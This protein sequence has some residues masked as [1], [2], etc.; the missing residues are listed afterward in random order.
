MSDLEK[1]LN[2]QEFA[3]L[4][5]VTTKILDYIEQD[6]FNFSGLAK[7]IETDATL[8]MKLIKVANS[9]MFAMKVNINSINQVVQVLGVNRVANLVLAVSIFSKFVISENKKIVEFINKVLWHSSCVAIVA[10]SISKK[11]NLS[12]NEKEFTF[13][14]LHDMGKLAML[15]YDPRR[16]LKVLEMVQNEDISPIVAD[17]KLFDCTHVEVT[18]AILNKWKMPP[19]FVGISTR[20]YDLCRSD[21]EKNLMSVVLLADVFC[22]IWGSGF[23]GGI[24]QVQIDKVEY[25]EMLSK[26]NNLQDFD[27]QKFTIELEEE[28]KNTKNFL[29]IMQA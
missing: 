14:I 21:Y 20:R 11:L 18:T 7:L 1:I 3:T 10:K 29:D 9:P 28:F 4:P 23:F 26:L 17:K 6:N 15:Q 12:L 13:G 19:D 5:E 22:E 8:S 27:L 25:W 2:I 16:Y 24:S